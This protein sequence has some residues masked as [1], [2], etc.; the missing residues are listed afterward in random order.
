MKRRKRRGKNRRGEARSDLYA[1]KRPRHSTEKL[2]PEQLCGAS[3]FTL[4]ARV[5]SKYLYERPDFYTLAI[6]FLLRN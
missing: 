1:P 2:F 3:L 5:D 4:L 6:V